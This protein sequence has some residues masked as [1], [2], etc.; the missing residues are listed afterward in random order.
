MTLIHQG[1]MLSIL[2]FIT[3]TAQTS[4]EPK[5][6]S[7]SAVIDSPIVTNEGNEI[8]ADKEKVSD[9]LKS[10]LTSDEKREENVSSL[11]ILSVPDSAFVIIDG[12]LRGKTPVTLERID[13]GKHTIV[14]KRR[15][16]FSKKVTISLPPGNQHTLNFDLI[17]PANLV[18]TSNPDSAKVSLNGKAVGQT[19]YNN[20]RLK[21]GEYNITIEKEGYLSYYQKVSLSSDKK[22]SIHILL[23]SDSSS[24]S[25]STE[26]SVHTLTATEETIK[27][28]GLVAETPPH[29]E[30]EST[31]TEEDSGESKPAESDKDKAKIVK[32]LDKVALGIF[33]GFSLVILLIE[34]SQDE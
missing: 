14:L 5:S 29:V 13:P 25:E 3:L 6:D 15:G 16:Y 10:S 24:I 19:P 30:Q 20:K 18:I 31:P 23:L 21:A 26:D 34:L 2:L 27:Q 28:T 4:N 33:L 22:D 12:K 8:P 7:S 9:S 11:T 1:L 32:V 17:A